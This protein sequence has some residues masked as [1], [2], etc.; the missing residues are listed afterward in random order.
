M[1]AR[2]SKKDKP[3]GASA[4]LS[5]GDTARNR[6]REKEGGKVL[7]FVVGRREKE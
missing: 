3:A 2:P 1:G 5:K 7:A 4:F 6:E